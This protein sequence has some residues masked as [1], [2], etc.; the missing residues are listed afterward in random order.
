MCAPSPSAGRPARGGVANRRV[1]RSPI[2]MSRGRG[3]PRAAR[4][5]ARAANSRPAELRLLLEQLYELGNRLRRLVEL[6]NE[7]V[8]RLVR[9][10]EILVVSNDPPGARRDGVE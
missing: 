9:Q 1:R 5:E 7:S 2:R 10:D 6:H 4:G 8:E 3:G